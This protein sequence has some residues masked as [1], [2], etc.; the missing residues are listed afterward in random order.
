MT[1]KLEVDSVLLSYSNRVILSD[2]YLK[3]QTGE[4][5]GI[6]GRNGCGKSS[7]L[8]IIFGLVNAENRS[9]RLDGKY[10]PALYKEKNAIKYLTQHPLFPSSLFVKDA[11]DLFVDEKESRMEVQS[12]GEI[13]AFSD[14]RMEQLSGGQRRFVE[15][16]VL[17]YSSSK[18]ILMD[19]PFSHI[20]PLQIEL[21]TEVM[22]KQKRNRGIIVTDHI[23]QYVLAVADR[24][25][26]L[27]DGRLRGFT[28]KEELIELG[29]I[30]E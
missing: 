28:E 21:I 12:I 18:F 16:M 24:R 20:S 10:S 2:I 8:K 13:K 27:N 14:R 6:L 3:V 7:L 11:I 22:D 25:Y 29:Y 15:I 9:V 30:P 4:V 19:E 5:V 17:L 26:F 1:H 23:Y